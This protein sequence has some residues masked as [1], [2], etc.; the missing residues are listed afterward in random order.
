MLALHSE[1]G[2]FERSFV[3]NLVSKIIILHTVLLSISNHLID[4]ISGKTSLLSLDL[5]LGLGVGDLIACRDIEDAV[6]IEGKGHIDFGFT[7][8]GA[9][10]SRDDEGS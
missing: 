3:S 5:G 8:A 2:L 6:G 7:S 9:L 10:D 1:K 4:I